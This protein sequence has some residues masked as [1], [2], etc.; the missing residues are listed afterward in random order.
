MNRT[1]RVCIF[2]SRPAAQIFIAH[3][4]NMHQSAAPL[5][6]Q[7]KYQKSTLRIEP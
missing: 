1:P 4:H 5:P 2:A 7:K 6:C 3:M